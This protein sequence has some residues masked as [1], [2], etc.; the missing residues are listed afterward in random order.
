MTAVAVLHVAAAA[1]D[2]SRFGFVVSKRVGTA[3]VR[4][5]VRRRM[6]E[7]VRAEMPAVPVDVVLRATPAAA[8]ADF[9]T[10]QAAITPVLRNP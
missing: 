3:V 6:S 8:S 5:R 7:I 4:N 2:A 10:L 9:A 1:S